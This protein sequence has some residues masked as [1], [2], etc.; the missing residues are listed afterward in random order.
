[1]YSNFG[2]RSQVHSSCGIRRGEAQVVPD[3][4]FFLDEL[5]NTTCFIGLREA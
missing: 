2:T 5:I 1:M 3:Q 4:K